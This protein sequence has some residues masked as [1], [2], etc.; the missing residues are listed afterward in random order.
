MVVFIWCEIVL[1]N[2]GI[3]Y[4]GRSYL[5]YKDE[6]IGWCVRTDMRCDGGTLDWK[7]AHSYKLTDGHRLTDRRAVC[8]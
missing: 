6:K 4:V 1:P 5:G 8:S 7:V 3:A 2:W